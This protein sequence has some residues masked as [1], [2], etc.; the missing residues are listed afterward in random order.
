MMFK[1][2]SV[3][4]FPATFSHVLRAR[5]LAYS[6]VFTSWLFTET[7]T[8]WIP[9]MVPSS[10][11]DTVP[12]YR[13]SVPRFPPWL[14]PENTMSILIPSFCKSFTPSFTQSA[15]VPDMRKAPVAPGKVVSVTVMGCDTVIPCPL[16][17]L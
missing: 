3:E 11:A 12:E 17:L 5:I 4:S 7:A 1:A 13:V 8:D 2:M 16:A 6:K 15:G 9:H 10:A 14:M